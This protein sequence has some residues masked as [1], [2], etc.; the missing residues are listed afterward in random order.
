MRHPDWLS[1]LV[2]A[3]RITADEPAVAA[4]LGIAAPDVG[5][6]RPDHLRVVRDIEPVPVTGHV[7]IIAW[8]EIALLHRPALHHPVRRPAAQCLKQILTLDSSAF[9]RGVAELVGDREL[10]CPAERVHLEL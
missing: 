3:G 9:A 5:R 8:N 2:A 6:R 10:S 7:W 4:A 1:V